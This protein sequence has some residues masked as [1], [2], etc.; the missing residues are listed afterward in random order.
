M[1]VIKTIMISIVVVNFQE[2]INEIISDNTFWEA[3]KYILVG[4]HESI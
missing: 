1:K 2:N 4:R 3:I